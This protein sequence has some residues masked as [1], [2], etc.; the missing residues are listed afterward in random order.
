MHRMRIECDGKPTFFGCDVAM[1]VEQPTRTECN[2]RIYEAGWRL[3]GD[4]TLCARC[5]NR[6]YPADGAALLAQT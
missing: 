6:E 5:I 2:L 3:W 4:R 1:T